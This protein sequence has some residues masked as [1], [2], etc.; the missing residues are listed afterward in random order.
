MLTAEQGIERPARL[1]KWDGLGL[2]CLKWLGL[3]QRRAP[4]D[5]AR[6]CSDTGLCVICAQALP[7]PGHEE[8]Y[9]IG[10]SNCYVTFTS[11]IYC[12]KFFKVMDLTFSP[13]RGICIIRLVY[14]GVFSGESHESS[15][16]THLCSPHGIMSIKEKAGD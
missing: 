8:P 6:L 2:T 13:P 9:S 3:V 15:A 16:S 14:F 7:D 10:P 11:S 1:T 12:F 5:L 4:M